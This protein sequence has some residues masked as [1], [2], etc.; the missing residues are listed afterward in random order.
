[1]LKIYYYANKNGNK[2]M[3]VKVS[4]KGLVIPP[5]FLEG[6]KEVEIRKNNG[7]II[8]FPTAIDDPILELGKQPVQCG[9]SDASENHD[10]YLY[11]NVS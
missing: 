2:N 6:V 8:L 4:K 11:D 1:M 5:E 7:W 3:K 10:K 9:V